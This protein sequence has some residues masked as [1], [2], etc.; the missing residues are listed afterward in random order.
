VSAI[1]LAWAAGFFDGEGNANYCVRRYRDGHGVSRSLT[2]QISQVGRAS[3]DRFAGAVGV[4]HVTGPYRK[5]GGRP[6]HKYAAHGRDAA[7]RILE[8]LSPYLG[9]AKRG[10]LAEAIRGWDAY[11]LEP[12]RCEHG[13]AKQKCRECRSRWTTRGWQTRKAG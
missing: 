5:R 11:V 8:L 7:A 10:Q 1:E 6:A 13:V 2:V 12:V 4:G 9:D 3:L